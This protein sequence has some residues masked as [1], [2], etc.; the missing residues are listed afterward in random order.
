[1]EATLLYSERAI[2]KKYSSSESLHEEKEKSEVKTAQMTR[3]AKTRDR[4]YLWQ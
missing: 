1:M 4:P 3:S 2:P